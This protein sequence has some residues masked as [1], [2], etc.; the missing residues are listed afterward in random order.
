MANPYWNKPRNTVLDDA[1]YIPDYAYVKK[2][3]FELQEELNITKAEYYDKLVHKGIHSNKK[4][5]RF[6]KA[7]IRIYYFIRSKLRKS[8]DATIKNVVAIMDEH[9]N[10]CVPLPW[11]KANYVSNEIM[12]WLEKVGLTKLDLEVEDPIDQMDKESYE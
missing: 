11:A 7:L 8:T 4:L 1:Q 3:I 10:S 5:A 12:E 9:T 2:Q 6:N